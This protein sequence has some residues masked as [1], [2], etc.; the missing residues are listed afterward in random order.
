MPSKKANGST[1]IF[2][3]GQQ[4]NSMEQSL[5]RKAGSLSDSQE[6]PDNFENRNPFNVATRSRHLP[7]F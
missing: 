3:D 1:M 6:I 7:L 4:S 2:G 5:S